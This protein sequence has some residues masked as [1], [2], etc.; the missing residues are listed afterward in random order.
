MTSDG[1]NIITFEQIHSLFQNGSLVG[2]TNLPKL[3]IYDCCRGESEVEE[4]IKSPKNVNKINPNIGYTNSLFD[5]MFWFSTNDS[6]LS[7]ESP[8]K[9]GSYFTK[10][11]YKI[12]KENIEFKENLTL[13][14]IC[15]KVNRE[16]QELAKGQQTPN[17]QINLSY[18]VLFYD[19][20]SQFKQFRNKKSSKTTLVESQHEIVSRDLANKENKNKKSNFDK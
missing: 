17:P 6:H 2:L 8:Q 5:Q 9:D 19:S 20:N 12:L 10:C 4:I 16:I 1:K 18:E 13:N 11:V 3:F 15:T 14:Q 7:F